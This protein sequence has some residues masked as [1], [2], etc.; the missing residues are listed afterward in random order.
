MLKGKESVHNAPLKKMYTMYLSAQKAI[1]LCT[2]KKSWYKNQE[3][4]KKN[5]IIELR[6]GNNK[7][8]TQNWTTYT[9]NWIKNPEFWKIYQKL[10][11]HRKS[12]KK[13]LKKFK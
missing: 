6:H 3:K 1:N 5:L 13:N 9:K 2:Q 7:K 12:K 11:G 4:N 8:V 10:S